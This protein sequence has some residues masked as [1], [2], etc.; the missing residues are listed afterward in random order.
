M[1]EIVSRVRKKQS[2]HTGHVGT[3]ET[4]EPM[5][6]FSLRT[7]ILGLGGILLRAVIEAI[8][9]LDQVEAG[10]LWKLVQ[11]FIAGKRIVR[12]TGHSTEGWVG[13]KKHELAT[14]DNFSENKNVKSK[15]GIIFCCW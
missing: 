12:A 6:L 10:R 3:D 11:E 7:S 8:E 4:L 9:V 14:D 2:A 13:M 5:S 15:V 1:V